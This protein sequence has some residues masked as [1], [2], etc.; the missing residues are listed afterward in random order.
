MIKHIIALPDG[1]EVSS[2]VGTTNAIM[3]CKTAE[4][5]N[6]GEELTIGSC[7]ANMLDATIL[8]PGH[9][10]Q[11]TA[12]AEVKLFKEEN[13]R[14]KQHGIYILEK[15]VKKKA[16][17]ISITG[18]DR[19][20]K[21]D[22]DLSGWVDGLTGWPYPMGTFLNMVCWQ[23]GVS[24][25]LI[26]TETGYNP[27]NI[28]NWNYP[29]NRFKKSGVTGRE[30]VRWCAEVLGRFARI[31]SAGGLV[32]E[33]YTDSGKTIT[34]GGDN[35][36]FANSLSYD[37][38]EV[39]DIDAVKLRLSSGS[40]G[41][42]WPI[43]DAENP[44]VITDNPILVGSITDD[45]TT[46]LDNIFS[47]IRGTTY[48]PCKI[49]IPATLDIQAGHIVTITDANGET[50][51][52][53]V[54][55]KTTSGQRD[56]L[57]C[58]GSINR[59]CPSAVNNINAQNEA[60]RTAS[61]ALAS[62]TQD[63]IFKILTNDGQLQG[64]FYQDGKWYI[65]A[66]VAQ[67]M[68]INAGSITAGK[69]ATKL[70]D[71]EELLAQDI[72]FE[73][74]LSTDAMVFFEPGQPELDSMYAHI[75]G[76]DS[77]DDPDLYDFDNDGE[78]T[79]R[80]IQFAY[81]AMVGVQSLASWS[82]AV[83][84]K[85]MVSIDLTNPAKAITISGK[86]MWGR[87]V[88]KYIGI[89][90]VFNDGNTEKTFNEMLRNS[91]A[92]REVADRPTSAA[93]VTG[94]SVKE[95]GAVGDGSTDDTDAFQSA[96]EGNRVVI[97]PGGTYVLSDTL[98]IRENCCLQLCQDTVLKFEQTNGNCIEMRGSAVLRGNHAVL[99]A[100]F[101][102]TG[103]V[104][105]MDTSLDG[106][107]HA[108]IP[109]YPKSDPMFKRQRFVYDVNIIKPNSYGFN[110][111]VS[112]GN[113]TGTAIYMHC[114]GEASITWMW[115]IVMSGIR[116]AGGFAY[117]IRAYNV[118]DPNGYPDNAW[119]HDMRIEAAIEGC[120][121][122]VSLENC[123]GAHLSVSVQPTVS[124]PGGT[125]YAKNG[126]RLS[127]SRYVDLMR[128]RVWDWEN[129][130]N[131]S[132]EYTHIAL[133]GNCRGLLLDDFFVTEHPDVDIRDDIYTDTP[134][135]F[136]TMTILQEQANKWFKS[137]DNKPYF[138]D[139]TDN[140]KLMLSS[141]KFT[142]EQMD[143]IDP[144][145]GYYTEIPRF[146]NLV[147]GY[148]DGVYIGSDGGLVTNADSHAYTT[149]D[150]IPID[151]LLDH[152]YRIGGDGISWND[153]FAY[154][155]IAWYDSNKNM[156]GSPYP[157]NKLG[158]NDYYP[159]WVEDDTVAA[160]F[161]TLTSN[162]APNGAAYFRISAKGSGANLVVTVDEKQEYDSIW[163]GEPKRFDKS[164]YA[165]N[166]VLTSPGGKVYEL[167]ID[168]DGNISPVEFSE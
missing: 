49:S 155:R 145:D 27:A 106:T 98:V 122:G 102:F 21:L 166:L 73:G 80:D 130:S 128:S 75:T 25:T 55:K 3:R 132:E 36:Y 131:D 17:T 141:D 53:L 34:P 90:M 158:S 136:D 39:A 160:A 165:Q 83:K 157:W 89:N 65:N 97:V 105:S 94:V 16:N 156:K 118:D 85:A 96:L 14:R 37:S 9:N 63:E 45:D 64:I 26:D 81:K 91:E 121:I 62:Q 101:G 15:P 100:A 30:I 148:Q 152:V 5:V 108:S 59:T 61:N 87:E 50:I 51:K 123:N 54:M 12:G 68:N 134:E 154:C 95:Y 19:M 153:T 133:Y 2:G 150:F 138:Y 43:G 60:Y 161:S 35:R 86:N 164:I 20:I 79:A 13:G 114:D 110:R 127:D 126:I 24:L 58:T 88:E 77:L 103:N 99:S 147:E 47:G 116:I 32:F 4:C 139:G 163:H 143:F 1:T 115:A 70:I 41:A 23:C 92:Y 52:A 48:T 109:P 72:T 11:L 46:V 40:G 82:G 120:E 104:I 10:L 144:A 71:V 33:W 76:A 18:Y 44:Y 129:A 66:E 125:K 107:N 140:K 149:T 56:T 117:G 168:D 67:I 8:A 137:V 162:T 142:A 113:C 146:T 22:K 159:K 31:D 57:E 135:N 111:P 84:T 7:F 151:G 167:R 74:S 78:I 28:P 93:P 29:V 38:Y 119:N 112:D 6:V 124:N 42:L 69:V